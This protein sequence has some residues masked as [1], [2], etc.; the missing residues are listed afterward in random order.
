MLICLWSYAHQLVVYL[1]KKRRFGL[2]F[3]NFQYFVVSASSR[4][5]DKKPLKERGSFQFWNLARLFSMHV[6]TTFCCATSWV[7][8]STLWTDGSKTTSKRQFEKY[9]KRTSNVESMLMVLM[10]MGR[11]IKLWTCSHILHFMKWYFMALETRGKYSNSN[12]IT[13]TLFT[14]SPYWLLVSKYR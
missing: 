8:R 1:T 10:W 4:I 13:I 2:C 3:F 14:F 11:A 7:G 5:F 9:R 12:V 6:N